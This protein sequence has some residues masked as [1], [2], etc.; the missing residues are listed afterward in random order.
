[1][2][3]VDR[4]EYSVQ[5]DNPLDVQRVVNPQISQDSLQPYPQPRL[6]LRQK[7]TIM[8]LFFFSSDKETGDAA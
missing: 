8:I 5:C 6:L 1:M 7:V 2:V 3:D 4:V